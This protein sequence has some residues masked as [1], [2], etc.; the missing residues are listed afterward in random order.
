MTDYYYSVLS[1]QPCSLVDGYQLLHAPFI[2]HIQEYFQGWRWHV[3]IGTYHL[4]YMPSH[5]RRQYFLP[6]QLNYVT[7]EIMLGSLNVHL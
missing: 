4:N 1:C 3:S 5:P 7:G 6:E 2:F